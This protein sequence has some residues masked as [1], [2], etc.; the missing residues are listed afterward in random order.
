MREPALFV[1]ATAKSA[2]AIIAEQ[3]VCLEVLR[4]ELAKR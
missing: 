2:A 1:A 4:A 3:S